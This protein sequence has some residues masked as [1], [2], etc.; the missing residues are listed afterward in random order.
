[1]GVFNKALQVRNLFKEVGNDLRR[2]QKA[3]FFRKK[4]EEEEREYFNF[5]KFLFQS[6]DKRI[7]F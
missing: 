7:E 1:M 4:A 2:E 5:F 6:P 3:F